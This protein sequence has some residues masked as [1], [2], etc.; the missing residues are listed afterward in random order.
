MV[1]G[2]REI[3]SEKVR[4]CS[5]DHYHICKRTALV[6]KNRQTE[7]GDFE[8]DRLRHHRSRWRTQRVG[9]RCRFGQGWTRGPG[10]GEEPMAW[11]RRCHAGSDSAGVQA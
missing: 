9:L 5:L 8:S 4:L 3:T 10:G 6:Q 2:R 1:V 11:R 7:K